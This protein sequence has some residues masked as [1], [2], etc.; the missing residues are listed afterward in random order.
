MEEVAGLSIGERIAKLREVANLSQRDL[1]QM[2][3]VSYSMIAQIER[4]T[5]TVSL[6]LGKAI[7]KALDVDILDVIG[8]D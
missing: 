3:G 8:R 6:Q 2:V 7:A 4:G 1:A 5:K